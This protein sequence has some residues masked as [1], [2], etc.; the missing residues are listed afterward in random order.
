MIPYFSG[1]AEVRSLGSDSAMK[2]NHN[3]PP[4]ETSAADPDGGS[5]EGVSLSTMSKYPSLDYCRFQHFVNSVGGCDDFPAFNPP[6]NRQHG[7]RLMQYGFIAK[8]WDPDGEPWP[9]LPGVYAISVLQLCFSDGVWTANG[10]EHVLYIGSSRNIQA[11]LRNN[12]P[13]HEKIQERFFRL[14]QAVIVRYKVTNSFLWE[15]RSLIRTIRPLLNI[16]HRN[17]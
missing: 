3:T 9:A 14:D 4:K 8:Q 12:H 5:T 6:D 16:H 7:E 1:I 10:S 15:E 13:W 11:R 2:E 17:G